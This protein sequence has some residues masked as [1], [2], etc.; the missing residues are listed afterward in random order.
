MKARFSS[1]VVH[2]C[3]RVSATRITAVV[4]STTWGRVNAMLLSGDSASH[5]RL[6][7]CEDI[8]SRTQYREKRLATSSDILLSV[9]TERVTLA[10]HKQCDT[11]VD[12]R[13]ERCVFKGE[14]ALFVRDKMSARSREARG[15]HRGDAR[16]APLAAAPLS[17]SGFTGN[18]ALSQQRCQSL[19]VTGQPWH[20]RRS[21]S[22]GDSEPLAQVKEI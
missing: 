5:R 16:T 11:C 12:A 3:K 4:A 6:Q 9:P 19:T 1:K 20:C 14:A 15:D 7:K 17:I 8:R 13:I 21:I 18:T 22:R 10:G 2:E